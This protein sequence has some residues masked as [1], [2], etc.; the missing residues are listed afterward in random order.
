M[1]NYVADVTIQNTVFRSNRF[2]NSSQFFFCQFVISAPV[3][4]WIVQCITSPPTCSATAS[5]Y[6]NEKNLFL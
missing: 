3:L 2:P 1:L 4:L 5:H 6:M